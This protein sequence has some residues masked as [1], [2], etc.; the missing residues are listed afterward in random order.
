FRP[1]RKKGRYQVYTRSRGYQRARGLGGRLAVGLARRHA[2]PAVTAEASV[3]PTLR[4]E[5]AGSAAPGHQDPPVFLAP[6][7]IAA[8]VEGRY[9]HAAAPEACVGVALVRASGGREEQRDTDHSPNCSTA[10]GG[11][12]VPKECHGHADEYS[13]E[14]LDAK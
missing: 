13:G 2:D 10:L 3:G 14:P 6:A 12:C 4:V 11:Q 1:R 8:M 5:P 9:Y 7:C